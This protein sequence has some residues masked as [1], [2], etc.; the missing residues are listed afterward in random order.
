M[1]QQLTSPKRIVTARGA[2]AS[3]DIVVPAHCAL[4]ANDSEAVPNSAFSNLGRDLQVLYQ[5]GPPSK[6]TGERIGRSFCSLQP[7]RLIVGSREPP[8]GSLP[9]ISNIT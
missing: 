9:L 6:P 4:H 5:I 8:C 2:R 7:A 1:G 3:V